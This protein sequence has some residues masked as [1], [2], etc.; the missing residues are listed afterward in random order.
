MSRICMLSIPRSVS[1]YSFL[2]E[3][4]T[5]VLLVSS[6]RLEHGSVPMVLEERKVMTSKM[7]GTTELN[8]LQKKSFLKHIFNSCKADDRYRILYTLYTP[9]PEDSGARYRILYTLYTPVPV[10]YFRS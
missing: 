2:V 7:I 1:T 10:V 3:D 5:A 4:D 6:P 9:V 8:F